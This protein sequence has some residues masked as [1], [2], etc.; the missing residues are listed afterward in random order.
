MGA[1]ADPHAIAEIKAQ[2]DKLMANQVIIRNAQKSQSARMDKMERERDLD[3]ASKTVLDDC[4]TWVDYQHD[5]WIRAVHDT[6]QACFLT[7]Q[8]Y[9]A[10]MSAQTKPGVF[11]AVLSGLITGL[12][13]VQPEFAIFAVVLQLGVTGTKE[14]REKRQETVNGFK[15]L[16]K[17]A[18][19]KAREA[20]KKGNEIEEHD[21]QLDVKLEF[22]GD[23]MEGCSETWSWVDQIKYALKHVLDHAPEE[24][25]AAVAN[26]VRKS[27]KIMVG[28]GTPYAPGTVKQLSLIFLYRIMQKYCEKHVKLQMAVMGRGGPMIPV[29]QAKALQMIASGDGS[30]IEFDGLDPAKRKVMY[31]KFKDINWGRAKVLDRIDDWTDLIKKWDFAS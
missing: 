26:D 8:L 13:M 3:Q 19:E 10:V 29:P 23:L 15:E 7:D 6:S 2:N 4:R 14:Q 18:F 25:A 27:W 9:N 17:E 31:D 22:F 30:N 28:E 12:S 11:E 21:S 24:Q 1:G 5:M 20:A 16:F